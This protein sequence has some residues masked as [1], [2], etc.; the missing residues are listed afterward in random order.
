MI[1]QEIR[2]WTK[3]KLFTWDKAYD[4][5]DTREFLRDNGIKDWI[6]MKD[7]RLT[8]KD[9]NKEVW[10]EL[11][12]N[13]WYKYALKK[14]KLIEKMYWD[15]KRWHWLWGCRYLWI[16]KTKIQVYITAMIFNLKSIIK[17]TFWV[18]LRNQKYVY[19]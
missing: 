11:R 5:W 4:N 2:R 15:Q 16:T 6:I 12:N 9:W 13:P 19:W 10:D 1:R 17:H 8:K 14:R 3:I 7:S 18:S